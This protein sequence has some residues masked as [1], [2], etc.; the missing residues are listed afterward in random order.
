MNFDKLGGRRFILCVLA[1]VSM[2][3]LKWGGRIGD[4]TFGLVI[5]GT[6]G[7]YVAGNVSQRAVEAVQAV[8][9]GKTEP[10]TEA[11]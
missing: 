3:A 5:L 4:D 1:Q 6:V 7:V 9:T 11:Q 10:S 2:T 8:K